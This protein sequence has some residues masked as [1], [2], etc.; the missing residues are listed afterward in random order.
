MADDK[1]DGLKTVACAFSKL[2]HHPFHQAAIED[3]VVR[4]HRLCILAT[5]LINLC[6]RELLE[7]ERTVPPRFFDRNGLIVAFSHVSSGTHSFVPDPDLRVTYETHMSHMDKPSRE[8]LRQLCTDQCTNLAAVARTNVWKHFRSRVNRYIRVLCPIPPEAHGADRKREKLRR[9]RIA[10]DALRAPWESCVIP[11]DDT[12]HTAIALLVRDDVLKLDSIIGDWESLPLLYHLKERPEVFLPAM[13]RMCTEIEEGGGRSFSIFPLR[14]RLV[15][16]F[17]S[18]DKTSLREVLSTYRSRVRREARVIRSGIDQKKRKRDSDTPQV[19]L[20]LEDDTDYSFDAVLDLAAAG[21]KQRTRIKPGFATDGVSARVRKLPR[22]TKKISEQPTSLP[23]RGLWLVDQLKNVARGELHVIGVD[24]GKVELICAAN[25][26]AVDVHRVRSD[27]FFRYTAKARRRDMR[28]AQYAA[29][30]ARHLTDAVKKSTQELAGTN[31]RSS[32]L[33][34]F[35]AY[36]R[37]REP[38]LSVGLPHFAKKM[39]RHHRW[40]GFIKEQ[41]SETRLYHSFSAMHSKHD[42][43]PLVIAYG[44]WG[45]LAGRPGAACNR[46]NP[47]CIGVGLMR[48]IAKRFLV[49]ATPEIYTSQ[50]CR[51]CNS[52]CGACEEIEQ[53]RGQRIRGLRR[54]QNEECRVFL[55]RDQNAAFNIGKNLLRLLADEDIPVDDEMAEIIE[56]E[57]VIWQS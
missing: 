1:S 26:D 18:F 29:E 24:P 22:S 52:R 28:T 51:F 50:T 49:V 13:Y 36:C 34:N 55:N 27:H 37:A 2:V 39:Y 3:A 16:A 10:T 32:R 14:R 25:M 11:E 56:H 7:T 30:A 41:Q 4:T 17:V 47:P 48:K 38:L 6:I 33:A 9:L 5:Q 46:G 12:E 44:A 40:K 53:A 45:L 15:P 42:K 21:I 35:C 31:S 8:G 19:P 54:C 57:A 43:R 20:P 23:R